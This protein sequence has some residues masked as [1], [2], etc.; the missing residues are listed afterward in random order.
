[1]KKEMVERLHQKVKTTKEQNEKE[2]QLKQE[3][4]VSKHEEHKKKLD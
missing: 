4:D 2:L 1:M 3:Q